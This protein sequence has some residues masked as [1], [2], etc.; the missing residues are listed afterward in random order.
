MPMYPNGMK[1]LRDGLRAASA[2]GGGG[3]PVLSANKRVFFVGDSTT[4]GVGAG[5]GGSGNVGGSR[6]YSFPLQAAAY[7]NAAGINTIADTVT[8]DNNM[9]AGTD[10][11]LYRPD[12]VLTGSMTTGSA[13]PTAG[14]AQKQLIATGTPPPSLAITPASAFDTIE[15]WQPRVSGGGNLNISVDGGTA[16]LYS[17]NNATRDMLR[18]AQTVAKGTHTITYSGTGGTGGAGVYMPI[19]NVYDSTTPSVQIF[20]AGARN[21][22]TS[23]WN[24][25][26]NLNANN[27][28]GA[29]QAV[30]PHV[31]V[32]NLGINDYRQT[33]ITIATFK[34]N[35]QAIITAALNIG[36]KVILVH[37]NPIS[38]YATTTDT[39]S[40]AAVLQAYLDLVAANPTCSFID[41]P[42]V[43]YAAYPTTLDPGSTVGTRVNTYSSLSGAGLYPNADGLH[44]G[45]GIY[46]AMGYAIGAAI[47]TA[48]GL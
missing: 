2:G 22:K 32:I 17:A 44:P 9:T 26:T 15:V 3:S 33:G 13:S 37:P 31:V 47:K 43:L 42:Q 4:V 28:I 41:T 30:A 38:A 35:M 16:T 1:N 14:G 18:I 23:D 27:P 10:W 39:W 11:P 19:I 8:S 5:S 36:A 12:I 46:Q 29:M 6:P 21:W 7:L 48:I 34:S 24:S 45:A 20:N 40:A 25:S